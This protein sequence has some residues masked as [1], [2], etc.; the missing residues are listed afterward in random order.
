MMISG[1]VTEFSYKQ[2]FDK[3]DVADGKGRNIGGS[4]IAVWWKQ[5]GAEIGPKE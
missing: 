5:G 1:R 4:L 2:G 3:F